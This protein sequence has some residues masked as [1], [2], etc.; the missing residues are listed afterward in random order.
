[1]NEEDYKKIQ[2]EF[3]E[4]QF[5]RVGEIGDYHY[6]KFWE[7]IFKEIGKGNEEKG[8]QEFIEFLRTK[9]SPL[10]G[11]YSHISNFFNPK[12]VQ[13]IPNLVRNATI[14]EDGNIEIK[15]N[16]SLEK[17][18]RFLLHELLHNHPIYSIYSFA[19]LNCRCYAF[20]YRRPE[21]EATISADALNVIEQRSHLV[22]YLKRKL[23]WD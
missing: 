6:C 21:I 22:N 2:E 11:I 3:D 1:M 12:K 8:E 7:D 18:I 9:L 23:G 19:A 20:P 17:K 4:F 13:E 16:C 15:Q 10:K 5:Y 14:D